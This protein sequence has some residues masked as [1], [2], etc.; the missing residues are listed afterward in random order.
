ML[1]NVTLHAKVCAQAYGQ[2]HGLALAM[3]C[4]GMGRHSDEWNA[5]QKQHDNEQSDDEQITANDLV[6]VFPWLVTFM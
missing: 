5:Q 4:F 6:Q 2:R 1:H 3:Q